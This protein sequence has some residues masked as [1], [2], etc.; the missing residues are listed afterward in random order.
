MIMLWLGGIKS[1]SIELAMVTAVENSPSYPLF[2]IIG[3][4][5]DPN[6]AVSAVALPLIPPKKTLAM[7]FTIARPPRIQPTSALESLMRRS[8][9]PPWAI[10][11]PAS[12][13]NG[14][15]RKVN[16]LIPSIRV[17]TTAIK[18]ILRNT[19]VNTAEAIIA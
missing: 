8:E 12:T 11:S 2:F 7:M 19:M 13:K 14:M 15:A 3:M 10:I 16:P 6:E 18:E 4:R 17:V 9:I 1:P 5:I